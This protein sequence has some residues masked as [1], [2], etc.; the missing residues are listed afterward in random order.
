MPE[1]Y[2]ISCHLARLQCASLHN[3]G[4]RCGKKSDIIIVIII[5]KKKTE[6]KKNLKIYG[7]EHLYPSSDGSYAQLVGTCKKNK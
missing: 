5:I 2:G 6:K 3:I 7:T 1:V 4:T